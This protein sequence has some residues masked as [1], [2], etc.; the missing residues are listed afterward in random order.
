MNRK[1]DE[2]AKYKS[3]KNLVQTFLN[4]LFPNKEDYDKVMKVLQNAAWKK[5]TEKLNIF[6]GTG[7]NGKSLLCELIAKTFGKDVVCL[8]NAFFSKNVEDDDG[9][10]DGI[11]WKSR[12][13]IGVKSFLI[14][15]E[16]SDVEQWDISWIKHIIGG[17][18]IKIY[19]NEEY[20]LEQQTG[21]VIFVMN[22]KPTMNDLGMEN[23][24]NIINFESS[25]VYADQ[26]LADILNCTEAFREIIETYDF[27]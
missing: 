23:R 21:Q 19:R 18:R 8:P 16:I 1:N 27:K 5:P 26:D 14:C 7:C 15:Q 22:T 24:L 2:E 20:K 25:F 9:L 17:D 3:Q 6:Y 4:Q 13:D 10:D 11:D 12:H